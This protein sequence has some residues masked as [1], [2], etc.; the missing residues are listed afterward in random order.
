MT[1][2]QVLVI[3]QST[4]GLVDKGATDTRPDAGAGTA[5][6][7]VVELSSKHIVDGVTKIAEAIGPSLRKGIKGLSDVAVEEV[8][9]GFTIGA[10]GNIVI[11]GVGAEACVTVTF[12]VG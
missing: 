7:R 6:R 10:D 5:I 8:S 3:E 2:I 12:K 9:I 4:G 1:N 11:A